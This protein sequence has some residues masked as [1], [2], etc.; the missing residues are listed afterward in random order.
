MKK[1]YSIARIKRKKSWKYLTKDIIFKE[2]STTS[3]KA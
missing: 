2:R 1:I 3:R